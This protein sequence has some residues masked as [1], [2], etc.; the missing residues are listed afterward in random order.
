MLL[1]L[2]GSALLWGSLYYSSLNYS[3]PNIG[4][5]LL[6]LTS[7]LYLPLLIPIGLVIGD[8]GPPAPG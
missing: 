7:P 2:A 6:L 4:L 1:L 3:G 8:R 5:A